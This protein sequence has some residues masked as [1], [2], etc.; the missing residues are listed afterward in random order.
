MEGFSEGAVTLEG[1]ARW[2]G[3]RGCAYVNCHHRSGCGPF[4]LQLNRLFATY[5][6]SGTP[7]VSQPIGFQQK[8]MVWKNTSD[9]LLG[10]LNKM[11][12]S[13]ACAPVAVHASNSFS[14][15]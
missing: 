8:D 13:L 10:F 9:E 15:D 12:L 4:F 1:A 14:S 3:C 5:K 6:S 2:L 11:N 7:I